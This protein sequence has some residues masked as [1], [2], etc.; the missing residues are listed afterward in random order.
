MLITFIAYTQSLQWQRREHVLSVQKADRASLLQ[1]KS[2]LWYNMN[3]CTAEA[4]VPMK[5]VL[6][7]SSA[8]TVTTLIAAILDVSTVPLEVWD[9]LL[10]STKDDGEHSAT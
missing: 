5:L 7:S 6:S 2:A 10:S 1:V 4:L 8:R 3:V 9:P